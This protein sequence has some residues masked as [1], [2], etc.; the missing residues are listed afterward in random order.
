[1]RKL[2]RDERL[3]LQEAARIRASVSESEYPPSKEVQ[4]LLSGISLSARGMDLSN[5]NFSGAKLTNVDFTNADLADAEFYGADLRGANF[6]GARLMGTLFLDA[7]ME[8]AKVDR[9][10]LSE[11]TGDPAVWPDG[12]TSAEEYFDNNP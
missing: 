2:S 6:T 11:T 10:W 8:G 7:N 12:S 5:V 1:M 4:D 3:I 9:S